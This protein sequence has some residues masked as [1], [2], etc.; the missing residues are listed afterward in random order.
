VDLNYRPG[1]KGQ[2]ASLPRLRRWRG[3]GVRVRGNFLIK[4]A[5]SNYLSKS[6]GNPEGGKQSDQSPNRL[7]LLAAPAITSKV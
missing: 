1:P 6:V 7:D 4:T 2:S 3:L 5:I